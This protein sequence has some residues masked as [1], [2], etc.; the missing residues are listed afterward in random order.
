MNSTVIII[1]TTCF[2]SSFVTEKAARTLATSSQAL[3]GKFEKKKQRILVAAEHLEASE[4]VINI[5]IQMKQ[6][7]N[8]EVVHE[9]SC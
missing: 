9:I 5:A 8:Q 3:L 2:I 6:I 1:I 7:A 4:N